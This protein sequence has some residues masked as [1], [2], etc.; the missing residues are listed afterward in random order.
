MLI[1]NMGMRNAARPSVQSYSH[2]IG[3]LAY[4]MVYS[5]KSN[6]DILI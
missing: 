4:G 2:F 1:P 6:K 3:F 5:N